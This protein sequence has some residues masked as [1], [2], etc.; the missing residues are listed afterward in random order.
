MSYE[1]IDEFFIK[2]PVQDLPFTLEDYF[3]THK[4]VEDEDEIIFVP[5]VE[6]SSVVGSYLYSLPFTIDDDFNDRLSSGSIKTTK[7]SRG[8]KQDLLLA[9]LI[10]SYGLPYPEE[11]EEIRFV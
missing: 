11:I 6:I 7:D 9:E 5:A 2:I 4:V 10:D 3:D 8:V 1:I